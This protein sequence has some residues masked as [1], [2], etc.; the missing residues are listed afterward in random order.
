M[1]KQVLLSVSNNQGYAPDQITDSMTL[2]SLLREVK[3]AID[4]FGPDAMVV[5]METGN[6]RGARFG[7][8]STWED[9]F[10]DA[11]H[12]RE[13]GYCGDCGGSPVAEGLEY[14]QSCWDERQT[15]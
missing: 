14:C 9:T 6:F 2:A 10:T 3:Q 12:D 7:K 4:A 15:S 5:T 13:N 8:I 1:A 11:D